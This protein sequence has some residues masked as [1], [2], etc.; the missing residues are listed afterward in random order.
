MKE[1]SQRLKAQKRSQDSLETI[2]LEEEETPLPDNQQSPLEQSRRSDNA[3]KRSK[4]SEGREK[5]A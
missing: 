1:D 2:S 4:G 3:R 5:T